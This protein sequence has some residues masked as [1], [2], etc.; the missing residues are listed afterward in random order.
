M[1]WIRQ[2]SYEYYIVCLVYYWGFPLW[3]V[4]KGTVLGPMGVLGIVHTNPF[5]FLFPKPWV[6]SSHTCADQSQLKTQQ[7]LPR[8]LFCLGLY[9][10][11]SWPL[12]PLLHLL[13]SERPL[14]VPGLT[15]PVQRPLNSPDSEPGATVGFTWFV[16]LSQASL[17][18]RPKCPL[19]RKP[20][21][22]I[23][24]LIFFQLFQVRG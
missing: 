10:I 17:S 13:N 2:N 14:A 4:V 21:F 11:N 5:L 23:F 18:F 12:C 3:L 16:S 7:G 8:I 20:L 15:L 19:S 24:C 9:P 6:D 1:H 22:H